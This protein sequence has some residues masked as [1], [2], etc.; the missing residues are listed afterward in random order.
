M[1]V[2]ND[3]DT[4]TADGLRPHTATAAGSGSG[5]RH[6]I[7]GL[8]IGTTSVKAVV[9]E[10]SHCGHDAAARSGASRGR[11]DRSGS[12]A[13][14]I[15]V[16]TKDT[17]A[18]R[19]AAVD[20]LPHGAREQDVGTIVAGVWWMR[21]GA[22]ARVASCEVV[23]SLP[24]GTSCAVPP[25]QCSSPQCCR[26]RSSTGGGSGR[27][28]PHHNSGWCHRPNAWRSQMASASWWQGAAGC[29]FFACD[30]GGPPLQRGLCATLQP[31]RRLYNT[32]VATGVWLWLHY[33]GVVRKAQSRAAG[34]V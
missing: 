21:H 18:E 20:P 19:G 22:H 8:D 25:C 2:G 3:V 14:V 33:A 5:S 6:A 4:S 11:G 29:V 9:I 7:L 30:V 34:L 31:H 10:C 12:A 23:C 13:R 28:P 15:A 16:A 26:T 32:S 24:L 1:G 17:D 27:S